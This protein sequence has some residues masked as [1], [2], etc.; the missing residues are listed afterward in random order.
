MHGNMGSELPKLMSRSLQSSASISPTQLLL[1]PRLRPA[2]LEDSED[3]THELDCPLSADKDTEE[4][5]QLRKPQLLVRLNLCQ[6]RKPQ[7]LVRRAPIH[8]LGR[9]VADARSQA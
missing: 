6:L 8:L 9:G 4:V 5:C 1:I 2:F 7:L 3:S